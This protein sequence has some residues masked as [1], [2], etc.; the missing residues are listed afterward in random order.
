MAAKIL[1]RLMF[2]FDESI[3]TNRPVFRSVVSMTYAITGVP[4]MLTSFY[5]IL[6]SPNGSRMTEVRATGIVQPF[7]FWI[8]SFGVKCA[9]TAFLYIPPI[10]IIY[11]LYRDYY[12]WELHGWGLLGKKRPSDLTTRKSN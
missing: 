7:I 3:L 2:I 11:W 6:G 8:S 9:L 12:I 5:S 10:W 1:K 4:L